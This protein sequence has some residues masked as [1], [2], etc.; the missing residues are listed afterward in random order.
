MAAG[1]TL[2]CPVR[3]RLKAKARS[4]DG[5]TPTEERFRV[6]MLR[7]LIDRG[8]PKENIRVEAVIKRFGNA[9]RNSF[10]ADVAV[11]DVPVGAIPDADVDTL[12]KHAVVLGEVKRDHVGAVAAKAYQ[13]KPMLD[14]A[15]REDCVAL[16]W[17]DVE[18]RVYW[19]TRIGGQRV[20]HEG[21]LTD[22]PGFKQTPGASPLTFGTISSD[23]A[24]VTVFKRIEDVLHSGSLGPSKR[25]RVMLQLLLAK[26]HDEHAH[27][28]EPDAPLDLQDFAALGVDAVTA[29]SVVDGIVKSA[30]G[31]YQ[32]FLP[33]PVEKVLPSAVTGDT[34]ME[35]MRILAPIK[36][37]SMTH[38]VI[39]DFYMYFA[40]Y[41]YKWDLAQYFTPTSV[42]DFIVDVLNPRQYER[43]HDPACGSAD[44]LT[45][46]FR[47]GQRWHDYASSV[48]GSDVSKEAVQ[49]AV[50]NMILNGDGKTNIHEEDSLSKIESKDC[51]YNIVIC[52]PPFGTK[53]TERNSTTLANFDLGH[54]WVQ[55]DR[56]GWQTSDRRLDK[57]ESGVLFA[58]TCAR[59]VQPGGRFALIVPNGYLGNRS[60]RYTILREWILRHCRIAVIVGL[61]R[62]AFAASG[63]SVAASI[64]FCERRA[65]PLARS[66]ESDDYEFC[67]EIVDRVGWKL[68]D[69]RGEPVYKRDSEDGTYLVNAED[70]QILDSDFSEIL[71]RIRASDAAQY[72]PW[73]VRGLPSGRD[74]G[75]DRPGW[76]VSINDVLRDELRTLD[77]KSHSRKLTEVRKQ[78]SSCPHFQLGNVVNFLPE[79]ITSGGERRIIEP[80]K[81]YRY[82]EINDVSIGTY[83]WQTMRGWELPTRGKHHAEPGDIYIGSIWSCV[84]KWFLMPRGGA[85]TVVTN[86]FLRLRLKEETEDLLL[87][88]VAGLCSEAF[89]TQMRGFARGSDGLAE[90]GPQDAAKVILPR[91]T[92]PEVRNELYPFIEQL[93]TGNTS[94]EAKVAGLLEEQRLP[95]PIPP[96]RPHHTSI[97]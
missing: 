20:T 15:V 16:Y 66:E 87:D 91:I 50:L 5:L 85:D 73:L 56:G 54:E 84:S 24:L 11:L 57:Q 33:E 63:A 42:T 62:F 71:D 27:S 8:Y 65:K 19:Q 69:K 25:F 77:P 22:L 74:R 67:V 28:G 83:R 21:P 30:V 68:G 59:I 61:P 39:Q 51:K 76:T 26:L 10:R 96:A 2:V 64:I 82:I 89:T 4:A 3:G 44:F 93:R 49:V 75:G 52:N 55:D 72:F 80:A 34:L 88:I 36:I 97:V 60:Q 9:G 43:I 86:G 48:S 92:D 18:Y 23:R 6:E 1:L 47:R 78:I 17:D 31:Y 70:A 7:H 14:F 38:S 46:A 41:I 37:V 35:V 45:A 81:V 58:E 29:K 40:K 95:L 94:I 32:S 13:V 79:G 12:L 53:I 90:I